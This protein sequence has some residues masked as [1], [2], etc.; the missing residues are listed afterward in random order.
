[1]GWKGISKRGWMDCVK[2]RKGKERKGKEREGWI[3]WGDETLCPA[4]NLAKCS[5]LEN[6]ALY[7]GTPTQ[8]KARRTDSAPSQVSGMGGT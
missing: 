4:Q 1:M 2:K 5:Q 7:P 8:L 6:A 3:A